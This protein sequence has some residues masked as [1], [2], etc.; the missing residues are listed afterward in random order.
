M[1]SSRLFI[2][3][4]GVAAIASSGTV[5]RAQAV[6]V[7][8]PVIPT[9]AVP[10][11]PIAPIARDG[12][13]GR[14]YLRKPPGSGPFPAVLFLHPHNVEFP[15][16]AL[17]DF[18]D[19]GPLPSRFLAAGY[20]IAVTTY[21]SRDID[22]QARDATEDSLAALAFLGDLPYVDSD[23]V[24]VYGCSNGGDLALEIAAATDV[25]AVAVEEPASVMFTG[26]FNRNSPKAGERYTAADGFPIMA[27]PARYYTEEYQRLTQAKVAA[28][29]SPILLLQGD[30]NSTGNLWNASV[31]IPELRRAGKNLTINVYPGE[32][33][34]FA[35]GRI[36]DLPLLKTPRPAV[37]FRAFQD[38]EAFFRRHLKAQP[39]ALASDMVEHVVAV[40]VE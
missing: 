5:P 36:A 11:Q 30:E 15:D 25:A 27:N 10:L 26:V 34:C 18:A 23:S 22:P 38:T 29:R 13:R 9:T 1:R 28:I 39:R 31:L 37:A 32:P 33:H 40:P 21:R 35:F 19:T 3:I 24:G 6:A 7:T 8:R 17:K 2:I 14:G 4:I 12:H 20:V 16:A